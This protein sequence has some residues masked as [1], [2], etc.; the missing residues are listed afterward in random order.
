VRILKTYGHDAIAVMT[1]DPYR[2]ARDI[3]GIG[4][5]SRTILRT[6]VSPSSPKSW[7][8]VIRSFPVEFDEDFAALMCFRPRNLELLLR[9]FPSIPK[10]S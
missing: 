2:L 4:L 10:S 6:A 8:S 3:R 9:S 7:L 1:E 5:I